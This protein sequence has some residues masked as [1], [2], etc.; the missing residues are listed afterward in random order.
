V[1]NASEFIT[2]LIDG[3]KLA[4]GGTASATEFIGL[5]ITPAQSG[6]LRLA[7]IGS[8]TT[9]ELE[10]DEATGKWLIRIV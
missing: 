1:E 5:T 2:Y 6:A 7:P 8:V 10:R 4:V 9:F 3:A